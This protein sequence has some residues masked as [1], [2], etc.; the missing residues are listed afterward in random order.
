MSASHAR[1]R[2]D[3][4]ELRGSHARLRAD[5]AG[6]RASRRRIVDA[7]RI[8]QQRLERDLHDGVQQRLVALSL[9][10]GMIEAALAGPPE[11]RERLVHARAETLDCLQELRDL[12]DGLHPAVVSNHGLAVALEGLAARSGGR[13]RLELDVPDRLPEPL[14]VL[15]YFVVADRL[16]AASHAT[17]AVRRNG[18]AGVI[19]EVIGDATTTD[20]G[21]LADRVEALGG[22][23]RVDTP[24]GGGTRVLAE[25][26][27][28]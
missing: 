17:V 10:L 13:V 28:G 19:V 23:L 3:L 16:A 8:A 27:R 7:T 6:L 4:V 15:A 20:G 25:I 26:P 2:A 18:E 9:E 22:S 5:L 24:P 21:A 11:L 12:A 1:L 14:G